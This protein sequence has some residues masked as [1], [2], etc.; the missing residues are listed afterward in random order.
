[1]IPP[2]ARSKPR[3]ARP[4]RVA[5]L[6]ASP[7]SAISA[8]RLGALRCL[9]CSRGT[10]GSSHVQ[11]DGPHCDA[12]RAAAGACRAA[13]EAGPAVSGAGDWRLVARACTS[14]SPT[15]GSGG[16]PSH[17]SWRP[18]SAAPS[19]TTAGATGRR[20]RAIA[21]RV[22]R[23]EFLQQMLYIGTGNLT[24]SDRLSEHL[25]EYELRA[26]LDG[27]RYLQLVQRVVA[28][29]R[30]AQP[31]V[32][33]HRPDAGAHGE[34]LREH[35]RAAARA[36]GVHR[37]DHRA[38]ARAARRRPHAAGD[39]RRPASLEQ[40]AAQAGRRRS[41]RRCWRHSVRLPADM[42]RG[43]AHAPARA[44]PSPPTSSG[45]CPA[46]SV[47]RRSCA[48]PIA[49]KARSQVGL[50]SLPDGAGGLPALARYLHDDE[51]DAGGDPRLGLARSGA[52][53]QGDGAHR[54]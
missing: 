16:W 17:R 4:D 23:K 45:S 52:D 24:P 44:R 15:T 8:L 49:R 5:A 29:G 12:G 40:L 37:P 34:G 36:A 53:R 21:A 18:R 2:R 11:K 25:L 48:T 46:G 42:P 28:D 51:D 50:S 39:R 30:R 27:E 7:L 35:H 54:A 3:S 41:S 22:A 38:D 47:S 1:M 20:P 31:G 9:R 10:H 13:A 43:G 6:C 14:C 26:E 19:T 33:R 32:H